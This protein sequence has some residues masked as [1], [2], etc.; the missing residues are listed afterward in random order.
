MTFGETKKEM[1][2]TP[3][4]SLPSGEHRNMNKNAETAKLQ[5]GT[6]IGGGR[7]MGARTHSFSAQHVTAG[8]GSFIHRITAEL[9]PTRIRVCIPFDVCFGWQIARSARE[10]RRS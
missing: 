10:I 7:G 9:C 4:S 1:R 8:S 5:T 3:S 2:L 6:S